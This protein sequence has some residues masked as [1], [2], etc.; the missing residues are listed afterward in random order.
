MGRAYD[1]T[2]ILCSVYVISSSPMCIQVT[3][4]RRRTRLMTQDLEQSSQYGAIVATSTAGL[5]RTSSL[6]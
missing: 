1:Q 3:M 5:V 2:T 4:L 6:A